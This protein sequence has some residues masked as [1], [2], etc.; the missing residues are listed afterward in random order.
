MKKRWLTVF[1]ICLLSLPMPAF[2]Q[3][4][5][6][7]APGAHTEDSGQEGK[8]DSDPTDEAAAKSATGL[9]GPFSVGGQLDEDEEIRGLKHRLLWFD[10]VL[11]PWFDWKQ[12]VQEKHGLSLGTDYSALY[13]GASAS[14]SEEDAAASGAIRIFGQWTL[15]GRGKPNDWGRLIFKVENRHTLGTELPPSELGFEVGYLGLTGTLFND[16]ETF[17]SDFNWQQQFNDGATGLLVGR[18]DPSDYMGVSGYANP[19][20]TFSNLAILMNTSVALPDMGLGVGLGHHFGEGRWNLSGLISDANALLDEVEFFRDGA[21][22]FTE[23]TLSWSPS[24]SE[25]F[26]KNINLMVWHVDERET[27]GAPESQ[28]VGLTANWTL[29][30]LWMPFGR[31][32]WSDGAAPLANKTAT[33]GILRRFALTDLFGLGFN[34]SDPPDPNL[35]EQMSVEIFYRFQ[36]AQNL[37]LTPSFQLLID[38]ANNP[39]EDQIHVLGLRLRATL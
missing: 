9:G 32:G 39:D 15:V 3:E 14:L 25:R 23:A 2:S 1:A 17:L 19:W 21:E 36:I 26:L 13:Q 4:G 34:W 22:F 10:R 37:A 7:R 38:P 16:V 30:E 6:E 18:F 5:G 12:R 31:L 35:R 20:T 27:V 33:A 8:G 28:G 29:N 24:R 11:D